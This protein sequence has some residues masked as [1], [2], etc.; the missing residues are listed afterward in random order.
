MGGAAPAGE[1]GALGSAASLFG[2]SLRLYQTNLTT[3]TAGMDG[4]VEE[5]Y[6]TCRFPLDYDLEQFPSVM[7]Q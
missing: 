4:E 6:E 5:P 7:E 1:G 3:I 2:G